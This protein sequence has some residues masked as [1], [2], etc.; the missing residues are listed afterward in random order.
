M[1]GRAAAL[2]FLSLLALIT[3][4]Q[5]PVGSRQLPSSTSSQ[6]LP[7]TQTPQ[8]VTAPGQPAKP[9]PSQK[10]TGDSTPEPYTDSIRILCLY[11]SI[12]A[13]GFEGKEPM[14]GPKNIFNKMSKMHGGHASIEYAPDKALSFQPK[15][16][17][18]V[19]RS[20]HLT[21]RSNAKNFNSCFRIYTAQ[22]AWTVLGNYY[23]NL[24]SLRRAT[25]VIPV[26]ATQKK[27]LD[28]IAQAYVQ[29][30]PYD[31]SFL[32]MRCAS[33]SYEVLA[34][35]GIVA[36]YKHNFWVNIFTTRRLRYILY[37][38]YLRNKDKGWRLYTSKGSQSR[39]W[40]KDQ[41]NFT[42]Y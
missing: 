42:H 26:T 18:G 36:D 11:G 15:Q 12:P 3:P 31:Y 6:S 5:E 8:P 13:K 7:S 14:Y 35:A 28:S 17:T 38:E 10:P 4:A 32:G 30:T 27:R 40:E 2:I 20:G 34:S 23:N 29:K 24:D 21:N 25:F 9:A 16:Y 1:S 22:R 39:E 33:A 41:D 19:A 37:K